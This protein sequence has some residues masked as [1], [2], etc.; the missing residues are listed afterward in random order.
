[1]KGV[2]LLKQ[3]YIED[4]PIEFFAK[5]SNISTS[6]FRQLFKKQYNMSPLQ[7]RNRLRINRAKQL[8]E[9]NHC[10]VAEVA[11]A[12]GFEN[13]AYFCRLYKRITGVTPTETK[14][15]SI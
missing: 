1:M 12:T 9:C 5:Q 15:N 14:E 10:T 6:L 2:L 7:Y 11:Y 8:L 13:V 4:L 3:T